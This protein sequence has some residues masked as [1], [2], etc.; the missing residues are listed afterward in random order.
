VHMHGVPPAPGVRQPVHCMLLSC[1]L[2]LQ[3]GVFRTNCVDWLDGTTKPRSPAP[4][5]DTF[6]LCFACA[7]L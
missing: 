3:E 6:C 7:L 5:S 1:F 2:H 4:A